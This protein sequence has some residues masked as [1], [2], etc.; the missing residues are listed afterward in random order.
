MTVMTLF[1]TIDGEERTSHSLEPMTGMDMPFVSV[2]G[3]VSVLSE[4]SNAGGL[5]GVMLNGDKTQSK[6]KIIKI[7][8]RN[9]AVKWLKLTCGD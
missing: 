2:A 7:I 6:S 9:G 5:G 1:T 3:G 4:P 8:C